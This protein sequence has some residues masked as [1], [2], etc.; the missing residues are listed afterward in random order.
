[1]CIIIIVLFNFLNIFLNTSN[2]YISEQNSEPK[3]VDSDDV[4]RD[5]FCRFAPLSHR[6]FSKPYKNQQIVN[7]KKKE[8]L[9]N[10]DYCAQSTL[11]NPSHLVTSHPVSSMNSL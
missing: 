10:I 2:N 6:F 3:L 8:L 1:M 7:H 4:P 11:L 9:H 5:S